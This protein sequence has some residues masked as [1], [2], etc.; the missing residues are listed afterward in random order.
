MLFLG[1][2]HAG[3]E[4]K[5]ILK[6][7]L[8]QI[9]SPFEDLGNTQLMEGDDYPDFAEK[10][11]I[12]VSKGFGIGVLVCDTGIGMCIAAN[13]VKGVRAALCTSVFMAQRAR[14]HN[15]ANVLCLAVSEN[16]SQEMIEIVRA[17]KDT[18]FSEEVRHLQR[19][20]KI[21]MMERLLKS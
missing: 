6:E 19:L 16:S 20:K 10:V 4:Y 21:S 13:K 2:D 9:K 17:F 8:S 15:N 3:F 5:E 7:H 1:A 11:A 18:P 14:E 12:R